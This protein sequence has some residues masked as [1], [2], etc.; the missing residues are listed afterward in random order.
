MAAY[1]HADGG[2][3]VFSG[4][5]QICPYWHSNGGVIVFSGGEEVRGPY[6]EIGKGGIVIFNGGQMAI[7][8]RG[9]GQSTTEWDWVR[10]KVK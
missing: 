1:S 7:T 9:G 3:V 4:G 8:L 10:G 6:H 2:A 5:Q